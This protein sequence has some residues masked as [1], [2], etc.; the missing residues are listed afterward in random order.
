MLGAISIGADI[1]TYYQQKNAETVKFSFKDAT[2]EY[3]DPNL[4]LSELGRYHVKDKDSFHDNELRYYIVTAVIKSPSIGII[5]EDNGNNAIVI[6]FYYISRH[7]HNVSFCCCFL[8]FWQI[9]DLRMIFDIS[10]VIISEAL[11]VIVI[12]LFY[13]D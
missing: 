10:S 11:L 9:Y 4:L 3:I 5:V 2:R 13:F 1:H 6:Y 7:I 12:Y 8:F